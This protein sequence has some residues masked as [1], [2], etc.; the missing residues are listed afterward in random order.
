MNAEKDMEVTTKK[1]AAE[2][3]DFY[4]HFAIYIIVNTF[5]LIQW[6]VITEG[7]GFPWFATTLFGWGIGIVAHYIVVFRKVRD[8][9]KFIERDK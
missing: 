4:I 5:I 9:R 7:K 1:I 8:Y 3:R 6:W 2:K